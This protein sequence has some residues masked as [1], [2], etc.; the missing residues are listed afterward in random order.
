M[1]VYK[2]KICMVGQPGV[3]KTSLV[4]RYVYGVFSGDYLKT[5]GTNIYKKEIEL[6]GNQVVLMLWDIM[7]EESFRQLLKTSYFFGA[8]ALVAI[9]DVSRKDTLDNLHEWVD[10]AEGVAGKKLPVIVIGNKTDLEWEIDEEYI[11]K[12]TEN[13]GAIGYVLTSAK[14]GKN[15]E[16]AFEKIARELLKK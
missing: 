4:K 6:D 1:D 5:L 7:G 10:A 12:F 14:T 9:A 11:K 3:G 8:D 16:I 2:L 15:V 13:V